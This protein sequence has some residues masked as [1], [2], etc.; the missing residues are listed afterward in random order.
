MDFKR[1]IAFCDLVIGMEILG[2]NEDG[3]FERPMAP[4]ARTFLQGAIG[5]ENVPTELWQKSPRMADPLEKLGEFF[6]DVG[7]ALKTRAKELAE[8]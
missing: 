1:A 5:A 2:G 7:E 4:Y 3:P 8:L 6:C